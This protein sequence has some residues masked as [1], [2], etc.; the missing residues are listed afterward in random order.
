LHSGQSYELPDVE[1]SIAR[2]LRLPTGV[3]PAEAAGK[4]FDDVAELFRERLG[5]L[6]NCAKLLTSG[7][8]ASWFSPVLS[9]API[10]WIL[11]PPGSP[12]HQLLQLLGTLC[13]RPLRL[14]GLTRGDLRSL[15]L[16]IQPTLLLDEPDVRPAVLSIL[17][18]SAHRG[19]YIRGGNCLVDLF[20]AKFICSQHLPHNAALGADAIRIS[21]IPAMGQ[22]TPLDREAEEKIA[23]SFQARFLGFFLRNCRSVKIPDFDVSQ[24]TLPLQEQAWALGAAFVGEKKLQAEILQLLSNQ[25]EENRTELAD[26]FDSI[27]IEAVIFFIHK[28]GYSQVRAVEVAERVAAIYQGRGIE[29]AASAESVGWAF[30]RLRIPSG[31]IDRT[32]NGIELT[33][34][35]C[36][37]VHRL[38]MSFGV[39]AMQAGYREGCVYCDVLKKE[40]ANAKIRGAAS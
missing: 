25:D 2:A 15:P 23:E 8:F 27:V 35:T 6:E 36:R 29:R 22:S 5:Q 9:M 20:G 31:R 28:K 17:S 4:L 24:L 10:I 26:T 34:S 1:T 12:K 16:S 39:C 19:S 21:L 40:N 32:G 7:I 30:K 18:A 11:V 13:R 38:A 37:L 33:P 14:V 3:A